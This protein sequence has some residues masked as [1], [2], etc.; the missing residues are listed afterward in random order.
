MITHRARL[1]EGRGFSAGYMTGRRHVT[2][3]GQEA[4]V[5]T[6]SLW[7]CTFGHASNYVP[8]RSSGMLGAS[9]AWWELP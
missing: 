7:L 6:L 1:I 3:F 9:G 8:N 5:V 2:V 4:A